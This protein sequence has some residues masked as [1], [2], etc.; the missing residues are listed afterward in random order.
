MYCDNVMDW[1]D[2]ASIKELLNI[3]NSEI[4]THL[5]ECN[6]CNSY[7]KTTLE[8]RQAGANAT[9]DNPNLWVEFEAREQKKA[10]RFV[11]H[12]LVWTG[13]MVAMMLIFAFIFKP[14]I[15]EP[16]TPSIDMSALY[17]YESDT[18]MIELAMMVDLAGVIDEEADVE[19]DD[20]DISS[21]DYYY[22]IAN[23]I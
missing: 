12:W 6:K 10:S 17:E 13:A 15:V 16:T 21:L 20:G 23:E 18:N 19:A 11:R 5:A 8:L 22:K 4:K 14:M 3:K 1:I 7:Y 2:E 9:A